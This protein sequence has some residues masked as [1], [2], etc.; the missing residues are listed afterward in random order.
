MFTVDKYQQ[1]SSS[2]L[3]KSLVFTL[4]EDLHTIAYIFAIKLPIKT[5]IYIKGS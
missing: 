2:L 5:K 1:V 4:G 3:L